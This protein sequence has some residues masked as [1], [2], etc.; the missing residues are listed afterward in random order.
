MNHVYLA[1]PYVFLDETGYRRHVAAVTRVLEGLGLCVLA[2]GRATAG[3]DPAEVARENLVMLSE[4]EA[5]IADLSPFRGVEPDA[6][7]AFEVGYAASRGMIVGAYSTDHRPYAEIAEQHRLAHWDHHPFVEDHQAPVNLMLA[8]YMHQS[9]QACARHVAAQ[10]L[11]HGERSGA[12]PVLQ[13]AS[14]AHR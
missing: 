14:G 8:P 9:L 13:A 7:T 3:A 12:G 5:L 2:P 6:G 4:C 11:G 10:L 1:G